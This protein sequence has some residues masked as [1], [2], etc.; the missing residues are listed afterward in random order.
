[1]KQ[2]KQNEQNGIVFELNDERKRER[3]IWS[4]RWSENEIEREGWDLVENLLVEQTCL[5]EEGEEEGRSARRGRRVLGTME[6]RIWIR[7]NGRLRDVN[8]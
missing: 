2:L 8:L 3:T 1:V 7:G 4:T 5:T 6:M